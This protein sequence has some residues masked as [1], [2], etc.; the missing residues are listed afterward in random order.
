MNVLNIVSIIC[1]ALCFVMFFY[2]KWYIKKRIV[3]SGLNERQTEVARL[4]AEIDRI[5]DRDSQLVEERIIKLKAILEDTDKRIAVYVKELEK[6]KAGETL[7]ASLGRG[8][9]DIFETNDE[10][11]PEDTIIISQEAKAPQAETQPA[12][13][14]ASVSWQNVMNE[15]IET[16]TTEEKPQVIEKETPASP[17]SRQHLRSHIDLLISDGI[18]AEE[19]ASRLGISIAEVYL[20][21]NLRRR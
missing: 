4:I 18:P 8:I 9:R 11:F 13:I 14:P 10:N 12:Q 20:A 3:S 7:Y 15:T 5:T 1:F 19:I 17:P 16:E 6:S 21:I 2:F